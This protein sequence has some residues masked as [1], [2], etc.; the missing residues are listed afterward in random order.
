MHH[1]EANYL[2]IFS[3]LPTQGSAH[4][5]SQEFGFGAT[6]KQKVQS[7]GRYVSADANFSERSPRK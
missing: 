1:I 3:G 4:G 2:I 5:R 7:S 6:L